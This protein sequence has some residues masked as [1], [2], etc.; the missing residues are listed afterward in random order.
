M[1]ARNYMR[2]SLL[3]VYLCNQHSAEVVYAVIEL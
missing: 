1:L 3:S 2:T